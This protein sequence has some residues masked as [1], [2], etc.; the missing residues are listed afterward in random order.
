MKVENIKRVEELAAELRTI[1]DMEAVVAGKPCP[2]ESMQNLIQKKSFDKQRL[3]EHLAGALA[4][5]K[6]EVEK[7]LETL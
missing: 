2:F 5:R 4:A 6:Q 7:E 3:M 1:S